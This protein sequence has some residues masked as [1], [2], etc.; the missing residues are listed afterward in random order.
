[1]I[2]RLSNIVYNMRSCMCF[3]N[4]IMDFACNQAFTKRWCNCNNHNHAVVIGPNP[5]VHVYA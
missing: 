3:Y 2:T 5:G 4:Q 1:M